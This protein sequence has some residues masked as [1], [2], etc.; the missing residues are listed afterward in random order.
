M[1]KMKRVL[2]LIAGCWLLCQPFAFAEKSDDTQG[3]DKPSEWGI[4]MM[5][6]LSAIQQEAARWSPLLKN[7]IGT[8][9]YEESSVVLDE[10]DSDIVK[11][12]LKIFDLNPDLLVRLNAKY[13]EKRGSN[14][15]SHMEQTLAFQ[16]QQGTYATIG[17][18]IYSTDGTIVSE[19]SIALENVTFQ[20]IPEGSVA[21][22]AWEKANEVIER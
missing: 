18:K 2:P 19:A 6:K 10:D 14:H 8:Y 12:N 21:E 16:R 15:I 1:M 20:P 11:I 5:P 22:A 9:D 17:R 3:I 4:S 13:A 7:D